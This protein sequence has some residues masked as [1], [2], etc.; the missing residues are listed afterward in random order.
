M[1]Y[2]GASMKNTRSHSNSFGKRLL[3][4]V[5]AFV[6]GAILSTASMHAQVNGEGQTPYLGWSTFSEQSINS[7]FLTQ[8][9]VQAESDALK[10]SGL[11]DHGFV[12]INIDSGWQG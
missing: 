1:I 6:A 9:N 3:L 8:T 7:G 10:A 11:Q 2:L 5:T 4:G 12:Y